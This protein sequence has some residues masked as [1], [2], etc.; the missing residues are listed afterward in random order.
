[1]F[2]YDLIQVAISDKEANNF[3][4]SAAQYCLFNPKTRHIRQ[5]IL[6]ILPSLLHA[7]EPFPKKAISAQSD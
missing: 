7:N 1:M 2:Y 6:K 5:Y 3:S 4:A